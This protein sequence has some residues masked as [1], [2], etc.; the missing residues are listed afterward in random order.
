MNRDSKIDRTHF[1][2]FNRG[3]SVSF[4]EVGSLNARN[5]A[6][7]DHNDSEVS[8]T[9]NLLTSSYTCKNDKSI[10][11]NPVSSG[12]SDSCFI[13]LNMSDLISKEAKFDHSKHNSGIP[14]SS[15]DQTVQLTSE[16]TETEMCISSATYSPAAKENGPKDSTVT[17]EG[18]IPNSSSIS[19]ENRTIS[20]QNELITMS[21]I[22]SANEQKN[23]DVINNSPLAAGV[24]AGNTIV[25]PLIADCQ[26]RANSLHGNGN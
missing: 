17:S 9:T 1:R 3:K 14:M 16:S 25:N 26:R 15:I 6:V 10:S 19:I 7:F 13:G 5:E 8:V 20:S 2:P 23:N 24:E 18:I 21:N 11:A 22:T 4:L 12:G